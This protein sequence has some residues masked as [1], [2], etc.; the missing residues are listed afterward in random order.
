MRTRV[1]ITAVLLALFVLSASAATAKSP[2]QSDVASIA[3]TTWHGMDLYISTLVPYQ[4]TFQTDHVLQYS[5]QG[6]TYTNG[7][8]R[9]EGDTVYMET[10]NHFSDRVGQ[11]TG[12]KMDGKGWNVKGQKWNWHATRD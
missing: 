8:W 3:G 11:I 6:S 9:Q 12:N 2:V 7:T 5:Y 4:Y 10:N 1:A